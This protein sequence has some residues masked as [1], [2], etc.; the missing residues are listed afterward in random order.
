MQF[1][2]FYYQS[3]LSASNIGTPN[4]LL[5][6]SVNKSSIKIPCNGVPQTP[7]HKVPFHCFLSAFMA[8]AR[9]I[10]PLFEFIPPLRRI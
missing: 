2:F 8:V 5:F 6:H 4:I 9:P 7:P 3:K 1:I 10:K